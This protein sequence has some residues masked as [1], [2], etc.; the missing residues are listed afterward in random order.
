MDV[1][2]GAMLVIRPGIEC[3][4]GFQMSVQASAYH[5]CSPRE[6]TG[7]YFKVEVGFPSEEEPLLMEWAED[8]DDPTRTVYGWVPVEIVEQVVNKHGG[9]KGKL[10][11][12]K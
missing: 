1:P 6:S 9:Y 4:D 12:N 10:H 2:Y 7:P 3:N 5:Y 8:A 11:S